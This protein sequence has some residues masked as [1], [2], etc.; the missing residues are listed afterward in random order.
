MRVEVEE[1]E[2]DRSSN[3]TGRQIYPETPRKP[4]LEHSTKWL[5]NNWPSPADMI[6]KYLCIKSDEKE[7][8]SNAWQNTLRQVKVLWRLQFPR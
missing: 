6:G 5:R 7:G 1:E 2:Q 4:T 3:T 8:K